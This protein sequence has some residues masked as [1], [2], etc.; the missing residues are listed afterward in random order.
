MGNSTGNL[1]FELRLEHCQKADT[2]NVFS[3]SRA[4]VVVL[5]QSGPLDAVLQCYQ[6]T[7]I[8]M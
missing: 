5:P 6:L 1:Q 2:F 8:A 4:A 7:D 3:G